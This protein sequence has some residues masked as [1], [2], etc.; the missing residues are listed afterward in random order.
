MADGGA[1]DLLPWLLGQEAGLVVEEGFGDLGGKSVNY[2]LS[3]RDCVSL[4]RTIGPMWAMKR[5]SSKSVL[6]L[7]GPR[8]WIS[9]A[10]PAAWHFQ[11]V[12]S[13]LG[14]RSWTNQKKKKR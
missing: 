9:L 7:S 10:A 13:G 14:L 6:N 8:S 5:A 11:D 3:V 4:I 2:E 12:I 1:Q